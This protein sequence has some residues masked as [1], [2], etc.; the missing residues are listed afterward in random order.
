M[1][2][3]IKDAVA[4][5]DLEFAYEYI[6]VRVQEQPFELGEISHLSHVWVDG[7]DTGAELDGISVCDLDKLGLNCYMGQ[8]AAII[9]GCN[10]SYGEDVGEIIISDPVVVKVLS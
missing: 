5:M 7:E 9:C 3:C 2:A 10:A 1:I 6:G 4:S 8:H